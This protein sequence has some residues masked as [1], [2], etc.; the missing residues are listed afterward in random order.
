MILIEKQEKFHHYHQGKW[1][2]GI[3]PPRKMADEDGYRTMEEIL[4]SD[5]GR[6]IE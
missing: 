2:S 1:I 4:P 5:Q 6:R 3:C